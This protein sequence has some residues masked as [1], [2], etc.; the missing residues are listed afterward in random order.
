MALKRG[1]SLP[2]RHHLAPGRLH[3]EQTSKPEVAMSRTLSRSSRRGDGRQRCAPMGLGGSIAPQVPTIA[4]HANGAAATTSPTGYQD[5]FGVHPGSADIHAQ[6]AAAGLPPTAPSSPTASGL[7]WASVAASSA[8]R[9]PCRRRCRARARRPD[10]TSVAAPSAVSRYAGPG[11]G[12]R[13]PDSNSDHGVLGVNGDVPGPRR[14][15]AGHHRQQSAAGALTSSAP[16]SLRK[17][18]SRRLCRFRRVLDG[19]TRCRAM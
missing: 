12:P 3:H 18:P 13:P 11:R 10:A 14:G 4:Q 8:R 19:L 2:D 5:H 9:R 16:V 15:R 17:P 6:A 1:P 7:R